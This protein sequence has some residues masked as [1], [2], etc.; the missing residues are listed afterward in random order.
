GQ[1]RLERIMPGPCCSS[2]QSGGAAVEIEECLHTYCK[3]LNLRGLKF[4]QIGPKLNI[5]NYSRVLIFAN[6]M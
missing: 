2:R 4:S 3:R 1:F 6:R 5:F